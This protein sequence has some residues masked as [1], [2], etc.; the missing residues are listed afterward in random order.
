MLQRFL[1]HFSLVV[2]F[3]L[4]QIGVVSHE[5]SHFSENQT[6]SQQDQ[7]SHESPCE[8]CIVYANAAANGL[9][10]AFVFD[11]IH[12]KHTFEA[13]YQVS[14]QSTSSFAYRARA[15]PTPP[16]A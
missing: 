9:V 13:G 5:I 4:T 10:H 2:L 6:Q 1:V 7:T 15:P 3:A 11:V 8:K 14:F 16:L 12:S